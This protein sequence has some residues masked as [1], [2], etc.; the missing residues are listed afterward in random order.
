LQVLGLGRF[1]LV[2]L[3]KVVAAQCIVMH[4]LAAYGPIADRVA[5]RWPLLIDWLFQDARLAVQVML[6]IGGFLA[7]GALQRQ[8]LERPLSLIMRRYLRLVPPMLCALALIAVVVGFFR[9]LIDAEWLTPAPSLKLVLAH[10]LLLQ[11]WLDLEALSVG[12]WYVAIDLQLFALLTF[13]VCAFQR[14][15]SAQV[16][17]PLLIALAGACV[18]SM[19]WFNHFAALDHC[20]LYFFGAY[21]LG[22]LAAWARVQRR[23][24]PMFFLVGLLAVAAYWDFPRSRLLVALATAWLLFIGAGWSFARGSA[25][26]LLRRLGDASYAVFLIHFLLIVFASALWLEWPLEPGSPASALAL[27]AGVVFASAILGDAFHRWVELPLQERIYSL[28]AP[29]IPET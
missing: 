1:A 20:A 2:D 17:W 24:R 22:V 15:A 23:A 21:G 18:A 29:V 7:A 13:L 14:K 3:L 8:P 16:T 25:G 4:H 6:V 5:Q 27:G 26:A 19:A 28:T 9:P 11:D 12:V 10:A